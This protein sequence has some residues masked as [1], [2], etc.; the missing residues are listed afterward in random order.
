[1]VWPRNLTTCPSSAPSCNTLDMSTSTV[2]ETASSTLLAFAKLSASSFLTFANS[3]CCCCFLVLVPSG[4]DERRSELLLLEEASGA[5]EAV[6]LEVGLVGAEED[7][8]SGLRDLRLARAEA[9]EG[10]GG[11]LVEE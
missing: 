2:F 10:G 4:S 7:V 1:M 11:A 6:D 9:A 5:R 3:A 8:E